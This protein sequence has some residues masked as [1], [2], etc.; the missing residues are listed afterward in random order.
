MVHPIYFPPPEPVGGENGGGKHKASDWMRNAWKGNDLQFCFH[1]GYGGGLMFKNINVL[2]AL[3]GRSRAKP[4]LVT[5]RFEA[6]FI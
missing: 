3:S 4:A 6:C 5:S 1:G 2:F